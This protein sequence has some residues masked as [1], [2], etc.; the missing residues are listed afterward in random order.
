MK[1]DELLTENSRLLAKNTELTTSDSV[2]RKRFAKVMGRIENKYGY[3]NQTPCDLSW[4]EIFCELGKLIQYQD[5]RQWKDL[6]DRRID[7]LTPNP[8]VKFENIV[9]Q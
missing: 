5:F 6:V 4:E 3:T 7:S 9:G 1:K 8:E 2:L